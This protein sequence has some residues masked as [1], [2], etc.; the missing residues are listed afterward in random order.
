M[1]RRRQGVRPV[2]ATR[3][4]ASRASTKA[5]AAPSPAARKPMNSAQD[6]AQVSK[7]GQRPDQHAGIVTALTGLA[8]R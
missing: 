6:S 2:Q 5:A 4:A 7:A 1:N 3:P 8:K